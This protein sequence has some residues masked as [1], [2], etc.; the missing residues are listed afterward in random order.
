EVVYRML[1]LLNTSRKLI[2]DKA[3]REL[4]LSIEEI[5]EN[6][7]INFHPVYKK[8]LNGENEGFFQRYA[9]TIYIIGVSF[10]VLLS[11]FYSKYKKKK[12]KKVV[13]PQ[14]A[15]DLFEY[16]ERDWCDDL[17]SEDKEQILKVK[18][19]L[20]ELIVKRSNKKNLAVNSMVGFMVL[21]NTA[22]LL[23]QKSRS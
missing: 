13:S 9:D 20:C 1:T 7:K 23:R 6:K 15:F 16:L 14:G 4:L 12:T 10:S 22:N 5:S 3:S 17:A 11:F 2:F 19:V 21:M 18:N 8:F